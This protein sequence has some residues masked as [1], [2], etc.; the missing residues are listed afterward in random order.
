[1]MRSDRKFVASEREKN[2]N[3]ILPETKRNE[4]ERKKNEE[5]K[6]LRFIILLRVLLIIIFHIYY[7]IS[8]NRSDL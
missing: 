6:I 2:I 8:I 3:I 7:I 4:R 5:Y 1:M